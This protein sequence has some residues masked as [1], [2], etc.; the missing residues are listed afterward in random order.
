MAQGAE[1]KRSNVTCYDFFPRDPADAVDRGSK[2]VDSGRCGDCLFRCAAGHLAGEAKD[3]CNEAAKREGS[4]L[5][6]AAVKHISSFTHRDRFEALFASAKEFEE[7]LSTASELTTYATGARLRLQAPSPR[8][9]SMLLLLDLA[10][11]RPAVLNIRLLWWS[12]L[13]KW[14]ARPSM[15]C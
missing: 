14:R 11:A 12:N 10:A 2:L 3:L 4:W 1:Q 13:S 9:S 7:W 6:T 15:C 5:R 8:G